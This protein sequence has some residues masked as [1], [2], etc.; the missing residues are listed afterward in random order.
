MTALSE[1]NCDS[2]QLQLRATELAH[3]LL[4]LCKGYT[5]AEIG[6][7]LSHIL[8]DGAKHHVMEDL[9]VKA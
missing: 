6:L 7:A 9:G 4:P 2:S 5:A 1:H 8:Y 3:K